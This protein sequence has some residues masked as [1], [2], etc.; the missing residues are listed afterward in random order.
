MGQ[1]VSTL[2]DL[3]RPGLHAVVVGINPALV[4]VA[5]GHYYQGRAGQALYRRLREVGLLAPGEG[6]DDDRAFGAGVGFTDVVK[7]PSRSADEVSP[8][9]LEHGR[10]ALLAKLER[11]QPGFVIFSFK[12][13]ATT[14]LGP[15]DGFGFVPGLHLGPTDLFVM[16]RPWEKREPARAALDALADRVTAGVR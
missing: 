12:G 1:E 10:G 9:E 3:L 11:C 14:L 5:T 6:F 13:A 7:R 15:F 16:P 8:E 2:E 4:S